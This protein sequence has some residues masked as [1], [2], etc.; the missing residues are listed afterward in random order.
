MKRKK[1]I[2]INSTD[3]SSTPKILDNKNNSVQNIVNLFRP[4]SKT[5]AW[6]A[7]KE[8]SDSEDSQSILSDIKT[9]IL[10][11]YVQENKEGIADYYIKRKKLFT[12]EDHGITAMIRVKNEEKNIERVLNNCLDIFDEIVVVDNGSIDNTVK[13][14]KKIQKYNTTKVGI[15]L[16]IYPFNVARCERKNSC[17]EDSVHSLAYFY[18][19]ALSKCSKTYV[20]KWDGDMIV[21][22]SMKSKFLGFKNKILA[23]SKNPEATPIMASPVG[24]TVFKGID[25][26]YYYKADESESEIRIFRNSVDTMF[27]KDILWEKLFSTSDCI[28]VDSIEPIFIEYKD[29]SEDEFSHWKI[30]GLGMGM[31]KR[32]ELENFNH[33]ISLTKAGNIPNDDELKK[34][35]FKL[36]PYD[37]EI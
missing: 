7:F 2:T 10:N 35:G 23:M 24:T 14:V 28:Q 30:G 13:I 22:D 34:Y 9:D 5:E 6:Y 16:Y 18:N 4:F 19:Y 36:Y 26:N 12:N 31:R 20:C 17:P 8:D 33:I 15:Y 27:V 11:P 21:T 25:K 32:R 3:L 29:V 37:L 1:D